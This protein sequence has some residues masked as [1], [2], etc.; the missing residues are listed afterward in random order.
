MSPDDLY[1]LLEEAQ[2]E[3]R[4]ATELTVADCARVKQ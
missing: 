3:R 4:A 2:S 1:E